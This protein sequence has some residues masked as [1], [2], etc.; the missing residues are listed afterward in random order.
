[1]D[2][3]V[4]KEKVKGEGTLGQISLFSFIT[5]TPSLH[6]VLRLVNL[7]VCHDESLCWKQS[8]EDMTG[9]KPPAYWKR[10][11]VILTS[12]LMV[13]VLALCRGRRWAYSTKWELFTAT[14]HKTKSQLVSSNT[15]VKWTAL[16]ACKIPLQVQDSNFRVLPLW[17]YTLTLGY[18][19]FDST[20]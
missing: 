5:K 6:Y 1:M 11:L 3:K 16:A 18:C 10:R 20:L 7:V 15:T 17:R 12:P 19:H 14:W 4:E 9:V 2:I 8:C 13:S